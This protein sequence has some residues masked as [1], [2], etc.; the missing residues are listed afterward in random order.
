[1]G[2]GPSS[3]AGTACQVLLFRPERPKALNA[4]YSPGMTEVIA[5]KKRNPDR[6]RAYNPWA[7]LRHF[8]D[9]PFGGLT[10]RR[11]IDPEG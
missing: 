4:A 1:M 8:L 5:A 6:A 3:V 2:S 7:D 11:K 9:V 10:R